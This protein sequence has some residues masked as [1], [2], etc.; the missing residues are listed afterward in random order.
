MSLLL[1]SSKEMKC[2]DQIP[3]LLFI[4]VVHY[5]SFFV[6]ITVIHIAKV[7]WIAVSAK[8][9]HVSIYIPFLVLRKWLAEAGNLPSIMEPSTLVVRSIEG[10]IAIGCNNVVSCMLDVH[11]QPPLWLWRNLLNYSPPWHY[12]VCYGKGLFMSKGRSC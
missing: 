3:Q 4:S 2:Q 1:P 5:K 9:V 10:C 7:L 12:I 11:V 8:R 6:R